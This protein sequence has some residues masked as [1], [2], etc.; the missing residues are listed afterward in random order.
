MP[1]SWPLTGRDE[2]IGLITEVLTG[3]GCRGIVLAGRAGVGKSRLARESISALAAQAWSVRHIAAT[4]TGRFVPLGAFAQW[5]DECDGTPLELARTVIRALSA[6]ATGRLLV[7]VDDAHLLDDLSAL[8]LHQLA[9][10]GAATVLLTIR[11]GKPSPDAVTEL[12]KDGVIRRLELQPLSRTESD[13]LLLH[14]LGLPPD[15]ECGELLWRLTQGNVLFLRQLV[16]QEQAAGRLVHEH[17]RCRWIGPSAASPSLVEVVEHQIGAMSDAVRDVVDLVAVG[18]PVDW[19][20]M[21]NLVDAD[22]LEEAERRELIRTTDGAVYA[23]HP[24]YAEVLLAQCGP[25]RLRRLRG[26]VAMAMKDSAGPAERVRRGLLWLESDLQPDPQ[27]LAN[28]AAAAGSLLDFDLAA[29]LTRIADECGLGVGARVD[30]AYNLVLSQKGEDAAAV[31]DSIDADEVPESAFVNDVILRAANL[32]WTMRSPDESWRVIDDALAGATGPRRAQ[33]LAF[34]ANQLVLAARPAEVVAMMD[35]VDHGGLDGYGQSVRLCSETLALAEVGRTTDAAA[36]AQSC[37]EFLDSSQQGN[38]LSQALVEFL[39]FG[40]AV[41]GRVP[42]AVR[43]A[44]DHQSDCVAKPSNARAMAAAIAGASALAAGELR[45][46]VE[47]LPDENAADDPNMVLINGFYRFQGLRAQALARLGRVDEA[48]DAIEVAERDWHPTYVHAELNILLAQAWLAAARHRLSEARQFARRAAEF[49]RNHGQLAREVMCLQTL[50]QLD[51]TS[52]ASRLAELAE[53]VDGPRA[54]LAA[55]YAAALRADDADELD[56]VTL[57]F[58]AIGDLLAAA[59]AAGQAATSHRGAG[60]TG[61]AISAATRAGDLAQRCGG[62]ISP[63]VAAS[64]L[65]IP[66]TQREREI[67]ALV[68]QGC[69]NREIAES[70]SLSVR[71]VEGHIYRASCKAG[72]TRRSD[73]AEVMRSMPYLPGEPYLQANTGCSSSSTGS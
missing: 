3:D 1:Y 31:I 34:R 43:I 66:F 53:L 5:V 21:V 16:E 59:D 65:T 32:M 38:F 4:A 64:R 68:A 30:L 52:P 15:R 25:L 28:A 13:D 57:D 50:V 9:V 69:A 2:E 47:S 11:S 7:F 27:V 70:M 35:T 37:T 19:H 60:R 24:M 45:S 62:A 71:T 26:K 23:G 56:R 18:E 14:V 55:R 54:P 33:L 49:T 40:L 41:A 8:V 10:Q 44:V 58:E 20:V 12:W 39:T 22:A 51:D 42:E 6:G 48:R 17:G 61:S 46:A 72:V 63:A 67:A 29:R 36:T 73:L